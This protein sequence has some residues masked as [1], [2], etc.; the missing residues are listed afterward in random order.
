MAKGSA[1]PPARGGS[2][3]DAARPAT[4]TASATRPS[5]PRACWK[6]PTDKRFATTPNV[7]STGSTCTASAP[8]TA[9]PAVRGLPRRD[10]RRYTSSLPSD[11]ILSTQVQGHVGT[12]ASARPLTQTSGDQQGPHGLHTIGSTGWV[13]TH[14]DVAEGRRLGLRLLSRRRLT[15]A[16]HSRPAAS[17]RTGRHRGPQ[18]LV[19][20]R[21]QVGC[22]DPPQ[23]TRRRSG[24]AIRRLPCK[25]ATLTGHPSDHGANSPCRCSARRAGRTARS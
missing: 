7:P 15:E 18:G 2:R 20:C 14:G 22:Y 6:K 23:R 8:G 5:T 9:G 17:D 10:A 3:A 11:N 19:R 4:T 12:I 21:P 16:V 13:S 1:R 25:Q 24:A